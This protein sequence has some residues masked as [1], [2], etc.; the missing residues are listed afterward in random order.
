M[1]NVSQI[2]VKS[3]SNG[4]WN[5]MDTDSRCYIQYSKDDQISDVLN[6]GAIEKKDDYVVTST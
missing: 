6:F 5:G 2:R 3:A 1:S 4:I